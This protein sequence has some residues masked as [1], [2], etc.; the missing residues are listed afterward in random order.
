MP[1]L[2]DKKE[3]AKLKEGKNGRI[4]V[5]AE[6]YGQFHKKVIYIYNIKGII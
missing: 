6:A 1:D 2:L 4:S 3:L 5:S